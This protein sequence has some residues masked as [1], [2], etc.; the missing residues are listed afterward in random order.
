M[1]ATSQSQREIGCHGAVH[2]AQ[3]EC[4]RE[5]RI[6]HA[7]AFKGVGIKGGATMPSY[8]ALEEVCAVVLM[9]YIR[10]LAG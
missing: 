5:K 3:N 7:R 9:W 10:V 8:L 2:G 1:T 4:Y 6:L